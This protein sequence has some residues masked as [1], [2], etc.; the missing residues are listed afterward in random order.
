M[1]KA[2]FEYRGGERTSE[3][4]ARK[5][6]ES[7]GAY[8]SYLP[9]EVPFFK[10]KEGENQVRIMPSTWDPKGKWG[11][12][13][14]IGIHVHYNVGPDNA[15]YLCLAKMKDEACPVC[16]ARREAAD[17]EESDKLRPSFRHLAWV[18]DRKNEKEGPLVWS[19]P[20]GVFKEINLRSVDRKSGAPV[21]IDHPDKGY[22]V[23]FD[24]QGVKLNTDYSG[25]EIDRDPSYLHD[26]EETQGRWLDYVQE[27]SLPD[28]LVFYDYEH[29][30]K[31]LN[32]GSSGG[33]SRD[34]RGRGTERGERSS[35]RGGREE[36]SDR[37][38]PD[39]ERGS[40]RERDDR[41]RGS[42]DDAR[43]E[44]DRGSSRRSSRDE[45]ETREEPARAER[46]G[47]GRR[48]EPEPPAEEERATNRRR[49]VRGDDA[50][51]EIPSDRGSRREARGEPEKAE[52]TGR[53]GRRESRESGGTADDAASSARSRLSRLKDR[54]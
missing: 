46:G 31:A 26:N 39:R 5:A 42:A 33:G 12:G 16:E 8:D 21:L 53:T 18:I 52:E 23:I 47:R 45:P 40:R 7:G 27:N 6:K 28:I 51:D 50:D 41:E 34:D 35:R 29:I 13:W 24:R 36:G 44:R 14:D 19:L 20:V 48:E 37:E 2:K 43:G 10:A 9:S 54:Q 15:A 25:V 32:G 1:A 4:I 11:D 38:E 30:E 49:L 17:K 22:D 3:S